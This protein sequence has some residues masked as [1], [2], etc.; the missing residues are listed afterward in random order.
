MCISF[1]YFCPILQDLEYKERKEKPSIVMQWCP[2]VEQI[3]LDI[4]PQF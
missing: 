2:I 3:N 4:C 1:V